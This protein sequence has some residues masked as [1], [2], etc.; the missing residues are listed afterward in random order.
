LSK[1]GCTRVSDYRMLSDPVTLRRRD[2]ILN[3]H[4]ESLCSFPKLLLTFASSIPL[5]R[6]SPHLQYNVTESACLSHR[7]SI[8]SHHH[9]RLSNLDWG[10]AEDAEVKGRF[11]AACF[12]HF[13]SAYVP[14][15]ERNSTLRSPLI[16]KMSPSNE[17]SNR[18]RRFS[19]SP[20]LQRVSVSETRWAI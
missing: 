12:I 9:A 2:G 17:L 7:A 11:M 15:G 8:T 6:I 18:R 19:S 10:H 16:I 20:R 14:E 1:P 13:P 3:H 5:L 4:S